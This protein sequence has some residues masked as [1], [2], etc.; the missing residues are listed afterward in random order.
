MKTICFWDNYLGERGTTIALYDYAYYNQTLLGNKS[1]IMYRSSSSGNVP[2]VVEKFKKQ[3]EVIGVNHFSEVDMI[4]LDKN[5][6][7]F[8]IIKSGEYDGQVSNVC[9]TC[10]HCVFNCSQ[11]HGNVYA[12]IAPWVYNNNGKYPY[13]PHIINLPEHDRNM[14]TELGIPE[15]AVVFGRHGGY[16]QFD[17]QFV[18]PIVYRVAKENPNIYF[19]FVN[20]KP[21]CDPLPNIIHL[22][23]I[24]DLDKKVEFINTCD[25]MM[26][27]RSDGEVFSLSQGEF[28][29][30]NKP[31]ICTQ[32]GY[33][34][35]IHLL[36]N[37]AIWYTPD[38][39]YNILTT[40]NRD[41]MKTKDWNA[42]K[43]FT[44]ENVMQIFKKVYI[45]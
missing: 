10:V 25:A 15:N 5:V 3:F 35:H 6:D 4:L 30:K 43:Q 1:I 34:G 37:K 40:F 11:P 45:D 16:G 26:W 23:K 41:E 12:S 29:F 17:I 14:R 38:N 42:Y 32:S 31:I 44:P 24:I 39:L 28:S 2:E 8:Y 7:I 18:H 36:Q 22:D 21:F 33:P 9:K 20:T 13:V 19:V 27:A